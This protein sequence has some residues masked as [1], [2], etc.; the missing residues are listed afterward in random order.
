MVLAT[1]RKTRATYGAVRLHRELQAD[2]CRISLWKVRELRRELGLK[3]QPR[4]RTV[5]TTDSNHKLPVA[6]N[7]VN[8]NFMATSINQTWVSDIT[9]IPTAE[10]WLYLAGIKDLCSRELVGFSLS[11]RIDTDLVLVALNQA[12]RLHRP[13]RGLVLHSDRGSQ[14]CSLRYQ[15]KLAQYGLICSMSRKGDCYDNAPMESFWSIL[16]N[17]L[18]HRYRYQ[19]RTEA[20]RYITEYIEIFYNRQRRQAALG[21]I[22]PAAF[23]LSQ[24]AKSFQLAA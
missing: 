1:H 24:K 3:V 9:Y 20:R 22:S 14:Y 8:R 7:L 5:R 10:G 13:P 11:D 21:Y 2:N 18:V 17:E 16:K 23:A 19:R 15:Q 4:K 6:P 12:V